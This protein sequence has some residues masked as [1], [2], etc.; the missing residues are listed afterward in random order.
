MGSGKRG[1][2]GVLCTY[3]HT[4]SE[5][6][7]RFNELRYCAAVVDIQ[8]LCPFPK[9]NMQ[10]TGMYALKIAGQCMTFEPPKH[11]HACQQ[12]KRCRTRT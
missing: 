8:W 10:V 2:G 4:H 7:T 5:R 12:M 9:N 3:R 1:G 6:C 11:I